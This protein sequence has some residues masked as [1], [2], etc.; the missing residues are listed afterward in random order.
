MMKPCL[1]A[2][3]TLMFAAS[4]LAMAAGPFYYT[5]TPVS[6]KYE[7]ASALNNAGLV[8][9]NNRDTNVPMR[10]G[11]I[12]TYPMLTD[13]GTLGGTDSYI[14][15]IN[16]INQA[17]GESTTA[18][19]ATHTF[20]FA[21]GRMHDLSEKYG[22]TSATSLN[23]RG[24]VAGA[25][26][27]RAVVLRKGKLDVFGPPDSGATGIS[28]AGAVAGDYFVNGLPSRAFLYSEGEFTNLGTLGGS[29]SSAVALND[30]GAVV[31]TSYTQD[32]RNHVFLY[33]NGKMSDL[34]PAAENSTVVD[35]NNLGQVVGTVDNRPFLYADGELV[36]PNTLLD[37]NA[38]WRMTTPIAINDAGQILSNGCDEQNFCYVISR[39]DP[40][41]GVPPIPEAPGAMMLLAGLA[42]L[43]AAAARRR[44][45]AWA[46]AMLAMLPLLA[47]AAPA[48][49][50]YAPASGK[51]SAAFG[52]NN[53]GQYA[54]NNHAPEVPF[55]TAS[56]SGGTNPVGLD[57]LGGKGAQIRAIN[58][59]GE[60]VGI[61]TTAD[62][63][64]HS[65]LYSSGR[66]QDLTQAYGL[67]AVSA[68]NDRGDIAGQTADSRA[69]VFRNGRVEVIG[70]RTS[71]ADAINK[72]GD[73][74]VT[75]FSYGQPSR[76]AVYSGGMLSDLPRVGKA[77]ASGLA[78]NDA[79]WVAG[80]FTEGA[81]PSQAFL[82]DGAKIV[83][84][85]PAAA[86]STAYDLNNLGDA[87]GTMDGRAF[88]YT[89]GELI[90]LNTLIDPDAD[91]LLTSAIA[92]NDSEQILAASCDRAGVFCYATMLLSPVPAVPEPSTVAMLLAGLALSGHLARGGRQN[93]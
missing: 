15:A 85:A 89:N 36:D 34:T 40:V 57:G 71:T 5:P 22:M 83:E 51:Y 13:V 91:L 39:F 10:T 6:G 75:Y 1:S 60:A 31:G 8:A 42:A 90:D 47:S 16:D 7:A 55:E 9:V 12:S 74:L 17:I 43:A 29:Y 67:S 33:Q 26:D 87:V 59:K 25:R 82:Y 73:V 50:A 49:Y 2:V 11:Y 46:A 84:L 19:G 54:V 79:G 14:R 21:A 80:Y 66:M 53:A 56:I 37:P 24:E 45:R 88:L 30:D 92:I 41:A 72:P 38:Y 77:Y 23:N 4:P 64:V 61:S 78:L 76:T 70:P 27:G 58:N 81:S 52:L 69:Y 48:H 62:N 86:S 3:L 44:A 63:E 65:F 20:L 68:I 18:E 93:K 28:N 35:I 32:G